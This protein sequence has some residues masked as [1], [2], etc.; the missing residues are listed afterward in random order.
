MSEDVTENATEDQPGRGC[1]VVLGA[2]SPIAEAFCRRAA[3]AGYSVFAAARSA[4][5]AA[6]IAADVSV[7]SRQS[8]GSCAFD[9]LDA[10]TIEAVFAQAE[11]ELGRIALVLVAFGD[12]GDVGGADVGGAGELEAAR[13]V[14]DVNYTGAALASEA[15]AGALL[16]GIGGSQTGDVPT[17][18]GIASVAGDRGRQSNYAYGSAKGGYALYLQGLRNRLFKL[19]VHVVT[20]KFGFIDTPMTHGMKTAIPIAS[21]D[22]AAQALLKAARKGTDVLYFPFFWRFIMFII[23]SIPERL[24][25]R[26]SL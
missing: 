8:T 4:E 2:T 9:A 7:R 11:Q 12:M 6:A 21:P 1:A 22:A 23:R 16:R 26:L 10:A 20:V 18:L 14:L 15:G 13:R 3:E 19:G 5:A 25:K 24:F 17:L